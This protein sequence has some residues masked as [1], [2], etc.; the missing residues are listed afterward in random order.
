[1]HSSLL[2]TKTRIPP[3]RPHLVHR[4]RLSDALERGIPSSKLALITAPAGYGKTTLLCQWAHAS[5]FPV[6]WLSLDR[7]DNDIERFL[8]Y[9]VT[10]WDEIQPGI[11]ETPVGLLLGSTS[12]DI[13]AVLSASINVGSALSDHTSLCA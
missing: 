11:R 1:M 6:A 8:R 3:H 10:A 13:D 12:P 9:L 2:A 5:R 7:D 4:A